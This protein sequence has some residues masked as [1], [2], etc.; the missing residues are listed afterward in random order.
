MK[1]KTTYL[2]LWKK[3]KGLRGAMLFL[4]LLGIFLSL[5]SI[6]FIY[7]SKEIVDAAV[8][9][10]S[11]AL[12]RHL[13][14]MVAVISSQ[15]LL[16]VLSP[17]VE[18]R[19]R[20]KIETTLRYDL[21][22]VLL[23]KSYQQVKDTHTGEWL[24][25]FFSDIETIT[26]GII[27]LI[28]TFFKR[29]AELIF[30]LVLLFSIAPEF[31]AFVMLGGIVIF[32][33][34]S[35]LRRKIK[36]LFKD[37]QAKKARVQSF[38]QEQVEH[39]VIIKVFQAEQMTLQQLRERQ[40]SYRQS[41]RR[42]RRLMVAANSSFVFGYQ[43]AYFIAIFWGARGIYLGQLSYG[44]LTA[45]IQ[46][47]SQV[48]SPIAA[49]SGS[50]S[51]FFAMLASS[52][53]LIDLEK[54]LAPLKQ[55]LPLTAQSRF[56]ELVFEDIAFSR[57]DKQIFA[58]SNF[59]LQAGQRVG[60]LGPS[61]IGKTTLFQVL[62]GMYPLE[63]GE[64]YAKISEAGQIK[65]YPL[66]R[67]DFSPLLSYVPQGTTL[68]SGTIRDNMLLANPNADDETIWSALQQ[69]CADE[70]VSELE[71]GLDALLLEKGRN[72]SEGQGQRLIIARALLADTPI[73]LYDEMTS[74]LDE[75]VE[76][77]FLT[78]LSQMENRLSIIISHKQSTRSVCQRQLEL[79]NQ[80][81]KELIHV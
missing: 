63:K 24:T 61:G 3:T 8:S 76:E 51:R 66:S 68:F 22:Q 38:L 77:Q 58:N 18:E 32:L 80:E 14:L 25:Y 19:L 71:G 4:I 10:D 60:L 16:R 12:N 7:T 65:S 2:W 23:R 49:M 47:V 41:R 48:M 52:E 36:F 75:A 35:Y 59:S 73:V 17:T 11:V 69:A 56:V 62:L 20:A 13:W 79:K 27:N 5:T 54:D 74:A 50:T 53:R 39:F 43:L 31:F 29:G 81:I 34:S 33:L 26:E 55:E 9:R 42:R 44:S 6:L 70:F 57:D 21:A 67:Y 1:G 78:N 40:L 30:A 64:I 15:L 28:S 45:I 46:L 37:V 72:L